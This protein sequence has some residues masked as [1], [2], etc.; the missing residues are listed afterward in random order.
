[1]TR[2]G[3]TELPDEQEQALR[4][5]VPEQFLPGLRAAQDDDAPAGTRAP[6]RPR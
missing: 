4:R 6:D 1:M 2:F 3:H 5:A